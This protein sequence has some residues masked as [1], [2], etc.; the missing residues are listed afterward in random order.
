MTHKAESCSGLLHCKEQPK[1]KNAEQNDPGKVDG[2][3]GRGPETGAPSHAADRDLKV[4]GRSGGGSS[5]CFRTPPLQA[6]SW[7]KKSKEFGIKKERCARLMGQIT[8]SSS[9]Q[10]DVL[11]TVFLWRRPSFRARGGRVH[12]RHRSTARK[13]ARERPDNCC[14]QRPVFVSSR[15]PIWTRPPLSFYQEPRFEEPR[16]KVKPAIKENQ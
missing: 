10:I 5:P 6:S 7:A 3:E 1:K 2:L 11:P 16:R 13:F 14:G 4:G 9:G 15:V 12:F 8:C